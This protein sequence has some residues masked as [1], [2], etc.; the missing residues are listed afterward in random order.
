MGS[1]ESKV[2]A[3]VGPTATGKS[4]L[5]E[6]LAL[7]LKGEIVSADSMQVYR[8]MDIGTAKVAREARRTVYHC[9]DLVDPGEEF[10]ASKFQKAAR[11]AI[12]DILS[13]DKVPIVC[14]GTGLYVRAAL[15]EFV[16]AEEGER[17]TILRNRLNA[18]AEELGA[19]AFHARLAA[20]DPESAALIHPNN[21]RRVVRAFEWLEE[22]SS[23]AEQAKNFDAHEQVY[24]TLYLG[25]DM[26][27]EYLYAKSDM[28]VDEMMERGLLEEVRHLLDAGY[29][30]ALTAQQAIGYKELIEVLAG[31]QS[32]DEAVAQ[33]KK[34]TRNYAKRQK[35]WFRRDKRIHWLDAR[36]PLGALLAEALE[37]S[38]QARG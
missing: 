20:I 22:G 31:R 24:P 33:I 1:Q 29:G 5:A 4:A 21:V 27:R 28:R 6:A 35:S 8:G 12:D 13:R 11:R 18:E 25:M 30:Q 36:L 10:N 19:E 16:S 15:E 32:L 3:I 23:Y 17:E 14:G 7:A 38:A 34:A 9:I 26:P 37:L 2:I